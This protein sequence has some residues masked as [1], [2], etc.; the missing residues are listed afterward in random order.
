MCTAVAISPMVFLTAAH[1]VSGQVLY[2]KMGKLLIKGYEIHPLYQHDRSYAQFDVAKIKLLYP[3]KP[4][5][6]PEISSPQ[7]EGEFLRVGFGMRD[8]LNRKTIL[9][10][11]LRQLEAGE[12][13]ISFFENNSVSGD[14]GGPIYQFQDGEWKLV[15]THSTYSYGPLGTFSLNPTLEAIREWALMP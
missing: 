6:F 9:P 7:F 10:Q 5:P 11:K 4:Y 12:N 8:G 13:L 15:A 3:L 1:C 14:S 2:I